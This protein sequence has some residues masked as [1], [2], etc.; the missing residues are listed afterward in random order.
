MKGPATK[1]FL[2]DVH[3]LIYGHSKTFTIKEGDVTGRIL[4]GLWTS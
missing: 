2:H 1:T 3:F 4:W